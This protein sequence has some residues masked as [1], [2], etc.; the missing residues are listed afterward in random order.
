MSVCVED[1]SPWITSSG[2]G[3]H[4]SLAPAAQQVPQARL[5]EAP[6]PK[7]HV[8]GRPIPPV[9]PLG[10]GSP[11]APGIPLTPGSPLGPGIMKTKTQR[12]NSQEKCQVT[13]PHTTPC[14]AGDLGLPTVPGC[15]GC[16]A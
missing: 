15:P 2:S 9:D 7:P 6:F 16:P 10:P 1:I 5:E 8:P 13:P 3:P 4:V 14:R 11:G 12:V